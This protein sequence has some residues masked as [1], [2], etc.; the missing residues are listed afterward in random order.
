[1]VVCFPTVVASVTLINKVLFRGMNKENSVLAHGP[2]AG[3]VWTLFWKIV[4]PPSK[5]AITESLP[6]SRLAN[7]TAPPKVTVIILSRWPVLLIRITGLALVLAPIYET[8]KG[9][10]TYPG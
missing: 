2:V 8:T 5:S 1:M 9:I 4:R 6:V 3:K 10:P 7:E